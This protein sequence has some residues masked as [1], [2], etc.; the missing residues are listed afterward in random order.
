[1][2]CS[3]VIGTAEICKFLCEDLA[4]FSSVKFSLMF[5]LNFI[6]LM[7]ELFFSLH[8]LIVYY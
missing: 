3:T 6:A 1:M 8:F 7:N 2:A 4:C 5:L